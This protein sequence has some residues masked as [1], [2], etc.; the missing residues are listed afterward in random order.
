MEFIDCP[1]TSDLRDGPALH[2]VLVHCVGS[3]IP[4][5]L[6]HVEARHEVVSAG[7]E[8]LK[9]ADLGVERKVLDFLEGTNKIS[10]VDSL[11]CYPSL[12][13]FVGF[14]RVERVSQTQCGLSFFLYK[15]P[16]ILFTSKRGIMTR[17][18]PMTY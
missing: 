7:H 10:L 2:Q 13:S 4:D 6:H 1:L 9:T 16:L 15:N 11:H 12:G 18:L 8:N 5:G 14:N 17:I 3:Y